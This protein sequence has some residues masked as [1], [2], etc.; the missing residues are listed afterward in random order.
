MKKFISFISSMFFGMVCLGIIAALGVIAANIPQGQTLEF[1]QMNYSGIFYK[2]INILQLYK[3]YSSPIFLFFVICLTLNLSYC[4]FRRSKSI[5]K[6][7]KGEMHYEPKNL[8]FSTEDENIAKEF[9]NEFKG[10]IKQKENVISINTNNFRLMGSWLTHVGLLIIILGFSLGNIFGKV[11]FVQGVVGDKIALPFGDSVMEITDYDIGYRSDYSIAYYKS[12]LKFVDG[13]HT[14]SGEVLVNDPYR[15]KGTSIYQVGTGWS[16]EIKHDTNNLRL[17]PGEGVHDSSHTYSI[18]MEELIP[19]YVYFENKSQSLTPFLNNPMVLYTIY[20]GETPVERGAIP[21]GEEFLLG[22]DEMVFAD[23]KLY[24][25][26]Q[27][28]KAPDNIPALIGGAILMIGLGISFFY[29]PTVIVAR[30]N[31]D[32]WDIYGENRSNPYIIEEKVKQFEEAR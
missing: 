26:L 14:E 15:Y 28:S 7:L 27:I 19:D 23:P 9:I 29:S 16:V 12:E 13:K 1:Y 22:N 4:T 6:I 18:Y 21:V 3:A 2:F 17:Y 8:V 32:R 11:T 25:R 10:K 30:K 31:E 5:V 24:T 20:Q